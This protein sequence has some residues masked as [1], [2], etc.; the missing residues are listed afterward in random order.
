MKGGRR[1][2]YLMLGVGLVIGIG[3]GLVLRWSL[4]FRLA[5]GTES[6]ATA[7]S[8]TSP[9]PRPDPAPNVVRVDARQAQRLKIAPVRLRA[10]TS[11]IVWTSSRQRQDGLSMTSSPPQLFPSSSVRLRREGAKR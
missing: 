10:T 1:P 7:A 9:A 3:L 4:G 2:I 8:S 11:R 5:R 6:A